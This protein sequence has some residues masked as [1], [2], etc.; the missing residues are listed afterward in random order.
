MLSCPWKLNS[1]SCHYFHYS[2]L[3]PNARG[4]IRSP[5]NSQIRK[6]VLTEWFHGTQAFVSV[7]MGSPQL[8]NILILV[9]SHL[10]HSRDF[11][12]T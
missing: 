7:W 4:G 12:G 3:H 6:A 5:T 11:E 10:G 8:R 9:L 2:W 1:L